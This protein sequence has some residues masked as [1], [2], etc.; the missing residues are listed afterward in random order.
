MNLIVCSFAAEL[1]KIN[2]PQQRLRYDPHLFNTFVKESQAGVFVAN[3][4]ALLHEATEH[5]S[6]GHEG[7][8]PLLGAVSAL[9][10]A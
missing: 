7:V 10:E 8:K 4:G 1:F 9:H 3:E 2:N 5:L 6:L